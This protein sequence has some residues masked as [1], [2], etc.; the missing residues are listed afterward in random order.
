MEKKRR[1]HTE[2]T[3]RNAQHI[4][5][6]VRAHTVQS[7]VRRQIHAVNGRPCALV[8]VSSR[9]RRGGHARVAHGSK[10]GGEFCEQSADGDDRARRARTMQPR[11]EPSWA[12]KG[13]ARPEIKSGWAMYLQRG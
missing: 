1:T 11:Q 10:R 3:T 4:L 6:C 5:V 13:W 8:R 7:R 12:L 9:R 2:T